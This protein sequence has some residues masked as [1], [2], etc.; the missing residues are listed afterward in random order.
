[1]TTH[2]L[3]NLCL[4]AFVLV[5]YVFLLAFGFEADREDIE[6]EHSMALIIKAHCGQNAAGQWVAPGKLQCH[7]HTGKRTGEVIEF[8]VVK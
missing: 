1:M 4:I 6:A 2:R 5:A 8:E 3:L 7:T